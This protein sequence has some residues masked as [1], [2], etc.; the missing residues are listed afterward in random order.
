MIPKIIHYCWLSNDPYPAKIQ[1]CINS[2]KKKLPGYE[3]KLWN[4]QNFPLEK[5][6]WVKQAFEAKK[7][8]FAADYIRC[9]ALYT[10]GGIY[11]D[12][13][14]EVL[15]KYDDLLGLPYFMCLENEQGAIEAATIGSEK[16]FEP[17]KLMLDYYDTHKFNLG[18]GKYDMTTIPVIFGKLLSTSF[19]VLRINNI[20]EF[21]NDK[22]LIC[23]FPKDYFSPLVDDR[24]EYLTD[25]T[26]SIH[27]Y[28][29]T[30]RPA[31]HRLIRKIV[32]KVFG[33]RVKK[34]LSVLYQKFR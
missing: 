24:L 13:D 11:L 31:S 2:W 21:V 27:H 22:K 30:W 25:N 8:A 4:L 28:T 18:N 34:I 6:E 7:Y 1:H 26:Y 9:Y 17:F 5:S 3:I 33:K 15:K 29:S 23:L 12:S 32:L 20:E 19:D 16:G 10:Y 14:V